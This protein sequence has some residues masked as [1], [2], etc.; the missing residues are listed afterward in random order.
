MAGKPR[1]G[2]NHRSLEEFDDVD[3]A[4]TTPRGKPVDDGSDPLYTLYGLHST[5]PFRVKVRR[6]AMGWG[7]NA[8]EIAAL[9]N[10]TDELASI[11]KTF[12]DC[13]AE[14][15]E[16]GENM[17]VEAQ[18]MARGRMIAELMEIKRAAE[19]MAEA[20]RDPKLLDLR[21]RL[22]ERI[23]KLRGLESDRKQPAATPTEGLV[24]E[25]ALNKLTPEKLAKLVE[26]FSKS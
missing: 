5:L 24:I 18:A 9:L 25:D 15:R 26:L 12:A 19:E 13:E 10:A 11:Q 14:W 4:P 22:L 7:M 1:K 8:E 17:T 3:D 23:A 16:L 21:M 6:L 20:S 2:F